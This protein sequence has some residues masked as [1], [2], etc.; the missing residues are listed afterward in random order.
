[1]SMNTRPSVPTLTV[2]IGRLGALEIGEEAADPG[3]EMF[4]EQLAIGA[5]RQPGSA[6]STMPA[7]IS[8]RIAA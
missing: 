2:E 4:V 3:R 6:G 5:C 7:M 8:H 1:M